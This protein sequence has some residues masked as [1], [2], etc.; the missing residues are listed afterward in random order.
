MKLRVLGCGGY[1]P[2][3]NQTSCF[4]VEHRGQL[5]LL[6]AGTGVANLANCAPILAKYRHL[7][8]ILSHFHLD[9]IIGLMYLVPFLRGKTLDIYG[10]GQA[11]YGRSTAEILEELLRPPYFVRTPEELCG[12]VRIF[13]YA[14]PGFSIGE[15]P[16]SIT[17]QRHSD[18]SFRIGIDGMLIYATDTVYFPELADAHGARILLHECVDIPDK[19]NR[20]HSALEVLLAS[21]RASEYEKVLL[22]HQNP[23]WTAAELAEVR[24]K[25]SGTRLELAAD[26]AEYR[27]G[28]PS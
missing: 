10:P 9:H 11:G 16:I 4:L 26:L 24:E 15:I 13:D 17:P 12:E 21:L 2:A 6:D 14:A 18:P 20:A 7:N 25:I 23:E 27:I 19:G 22:I 5:I 3:Q 28:E 1:M 8:V